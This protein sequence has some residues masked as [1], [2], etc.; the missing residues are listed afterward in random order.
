MNKQ[1][2]Y[3]LVCGGGNTVLGLLIYFIADH[4]LFHKAN[5]DLGFITF[6]SHIASLVT[7][8]IIT[9]PIGFLLNRYIVWHDSN[10]NPY[11]QLYRHFILV[12]IFSILNYVLLK[13][14][15]EYFNWWH[16]PSQFITTCIIVIFSYLSQKYISFRKVKTS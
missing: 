12:I 7:S 11:T 3:Y 13:L 16:F 6:K 8:I 5:V 4:F 1:S 10:L 9:F 14:F 2:Y 15:V